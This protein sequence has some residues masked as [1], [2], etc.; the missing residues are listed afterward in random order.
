MLK[1][2]KLDPNYEAEMER[3]NKDPASFG[4]GIPVADAKL[5]LSWS[6][7]SA[8]RVKKPVTDAELWKD[9]LTKTVAVIVSELGDLDTGQL[10][11][12]RDAEMA[13]KARVVLLSAIEKELS[14]R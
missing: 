11:T 12:M 3:R 7:L 2:S 10:A 14:S 4:M 6:G 1:P 9:Y 5:D 13:G 8:D